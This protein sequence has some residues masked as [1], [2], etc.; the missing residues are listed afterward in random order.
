V[1][2]FSR[3]IVT[4]LS[5]LRRFGG[6]LLPLVLLLVG[7]LGGPASAQPPPDA[8]RARL[9]EQK[10]A[11][12]QRM[13]RDPANLDVAFAY[14]DL[15]AK[16]GDNEAAVSALERMLLFNPNLPRV[17]LELGALYFRMGS[18]EISRTYFERAL[19]ANPP[20]DAKA[21]IDTYLAEI[22]RLGATRR[23]SGYFAFGGQ[24]QSNANLAGSSFVSGI[25]LAPEF[26]KQSDV[27]IF[28]GGSFLYSYDL[29][30]QTRDT[31]EV[32]GI[33]FGNHHRI[34]TRLDLGL[35][36]ATVG[37]RFNF[38]EPFDWMKSA[39]L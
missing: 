32:A 7:L 17:D 29:G 2:D 11:L 3:H 18:Y 10:E 30:T 22:A 27:N 12:F 9:Q 28:G 13:L 34:V 24:Y 5:A 38:S 36:E 20:A 15:A 4:L 37:P 19:A 39:S 26:T 33:G 1:A 21:R 6:P 14:A 31:L 8:E 25:Q 23:F 16:L 35:V